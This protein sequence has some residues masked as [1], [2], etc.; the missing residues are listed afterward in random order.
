MSEKQYKKKKPD[1][2]YRGE[3]SG[4]TYVMRA[5]EE[6]VTREMVEADRARGGLRTLDEA[7]QASPAVVEATKR[8]NDKAEKKAKESFERELSAAQKKYG[9]DESTVTSRNPPEKA[10]ERYD[11]EVAD[12]DNPNMRQAPE[13]PAMEGGEDLGFADG[14]RQVLLSNSENAEKEAPLRD[15]DAVLNR[16]K[17]LVAENPP[18]PEVSDEQLLTDFKTTHGGSFDPKSKTDQGKLE[19]LRAARAA[20][21]K[22]TPNQIALMIYRKKY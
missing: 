2:P 4:K 7:Y 1:T 12:I 8:I 13:T 10:G 19:Q 14:F 3:P 17:A 16:A 6:T 21:P 9:D 15:P 5:P 11:V 22:A 20:N 18:T